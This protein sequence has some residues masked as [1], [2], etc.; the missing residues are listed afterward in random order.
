MKVYLKCFGENDDRDL[1]GREVWN[2]VTLSVSFA[3]AFT[4][5]I[6]IQTLQS[7]LNQKAGLGVTSLACL[8]VSV[9]V[10][11]V[12]APTVIKLIGGKLSIVAAWILHTIYIASNFYP[13]FSTLIPS[14]ILFGLS[15]GSLWTSQGL[16]L[17][18]NGASLARTKN[19]DLHAVLSKLNGIFF[20]IHEISHV[21]GNVISSIVLNRGSY[22]EFKNTTKSCGAMDC[23]LSVN[24][25]KIVEPETEVVY[26]LLGVNLAFDLMALI[27][28][29]LFL[30]PLPRSKWAE[31]KSLKSSVSSCF[32]ALGDYKVLMLLPL[33]GFMAMEQAV[34]WA[35][36]T[37][38]KYI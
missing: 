15:T 31:G 1:V 4:A 21:S 14:S 36:F 13:A 33:F 8:Y 20:T 37:K 19:Q 22:N 28:T 34:L 10:S 5:H 3:L 18:T 23:P 29:V 27:V 12:C 11:G 38:V 25:T 35:D 2:T 7:S 6:S 9:I 16:F 24:A 30:S 32:L 26:V 17:S